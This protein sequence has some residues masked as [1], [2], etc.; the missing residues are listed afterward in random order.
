[1]AGTIQLR[2]NVVEPVTARRPVRGF[3]S[4]APLFR[5]MLERD[6]PQSFRLNRPRTFAVGIPHPGRLM[7]ALLGF[8]LDA[9]A[10]LHLREQAADDVPPPRQRASA[11]EN[12]R[13]ALLR[14]VYANLRTPPGY[15]D[16]GYNASPLD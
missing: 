16:P 12:A 11:A 2:P 13:L 15:T 6:M 9:Q 3:R 5:D 7:A 1:M 4:P 14:N 10:R 8:R